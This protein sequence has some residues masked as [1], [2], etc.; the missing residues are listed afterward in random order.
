VATA[1]VVFNK[2]KNLQELPDPRKPETAAER[3]KRR[4]QRRRDLKLAEHAAHTLCLLTGQSFGTY[5]KLEPYGHSWG[6]L[7]E[8]RW[9]SVLGHVNAWAAE[10]LAGV[11]LP[12]LDLLL[13]PLPAAADEPRPDA[14]P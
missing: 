3:A 4:E 14:K 13:P 6:A 8:E 9:P 7:S 2:H 10:S 11:R 5:F 12:L 1:L